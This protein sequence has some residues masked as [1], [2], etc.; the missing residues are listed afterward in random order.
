MPE[1]SLQ[2]RLTVVRL[3]LEGWSYDEISIRAGVGKGSVTS[4]VSELKAGHFPE[5]HDLREQ[6][7][8]LREVAVEFR[9]SSLTAGQ[10]AAGLTCFQRLVS[11]GVEPNELERFVTLCRELAAQ[12]E[13][14][15]PDIFARTALQ[16]HRLLEER[17]LDLAGLEAKVANLTEMQQHLEGE[18]LH[19]QPMAEQVHSLREKLDGLEEAH[20]ILLAQNAELEGQRDALREEVARREEREREL[21]KRVHKLEERAHAVDK[22]LAVARRATEHLAAM[23]LSPDDLQGLSQRLAA[24][25]ERHRIAAADLRHRLITELE[26]MDEGL[27]LEALVETRK[28]QLTGVEADLERCCA[29]RDKLQ[30]AIVR[31]RRQQRQLEASL[32]V[33]REQ[34]SAQIQKAGKSAAAAVRQEAEVLKR[35]LDTLMQDAMEVAGKVG[36]LEADLRSHEWLKLLLAL[37]EGE[38]DLKPQQ[39]R[40]VALIILVSLHAWLEQNRDASPPMAKHTVGSLLHILQGWK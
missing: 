25:A 17:G 23:G 11:L 39:V 27:G 37:M 6:V 9:Q 1:L 18:V 32:V 12:G 13:G 7:K 20:Q 21:S 5:A 29:E 24:I 36:Q 3:F 8:F 2:K 35:H 34:A 26:S 38:G 40:K 30:G 31:Q 22:R 19:L 28:Q 33:L 15:S 16:L 4:I 14:M 10:A